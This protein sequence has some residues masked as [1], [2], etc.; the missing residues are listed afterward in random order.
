MGGD[1]QDE[2]LKTIMEKYSSLITVVIILVSIALIMILFGIIKSIIDASKAKKLA[3]AGVPALE[4]EAPV[5]PVS[6]SK[7][8]SASKTKAVSVSKTKAAPS[9]APAASAKKPAP[10]AKKVAK[11]PEVRKHG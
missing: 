5:A 2:L 7:V 10:A 9:K 8:A 4:Q 3:L 11:K 6:K 1:Q